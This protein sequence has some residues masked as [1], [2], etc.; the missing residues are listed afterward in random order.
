MGIL[1][2]LSCP[3]ACLLKLLDLSA[4]GG[5]GFNAKPDANKPLTKQGPEVPEGSAS[6]A[7]EDPVLAPTQ[8]GTAKPG[9]NLLCFVKLP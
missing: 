8:G 1:R 5:T 9:E 2:C 4:E 3:H 7:M 6:K